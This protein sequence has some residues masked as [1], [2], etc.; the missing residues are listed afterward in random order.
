M[1][2]NGNSALQ[3]TSGITRC[4][5]HLFLDERIRRRIYARPRLSDNPRAIGTFV[6]ARTT[7][8]TLESHTREKA[9]E[10]ATPCRREIS[11]S[12]KRRIYVPESRVQKSAL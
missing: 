2:R 5:R 3:C 9:R 8:V 12:G 4:S 1:R 6:S 10:A 7:R 11:S